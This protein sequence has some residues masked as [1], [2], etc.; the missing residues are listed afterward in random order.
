M[1]KLNGKSNQFRA[2]ETDSK[3][4]RFV[5]NPGRGWGFLILYIV[6][7]CLPLPMYIGARVVLH[8]PPS[9]L[10][11]EKVETISWGS[12][13]LGKMIF[14]MPIVF[15]PLFIS[16]LHHLMPAGSKCWAWIDNRTKRHITTAT[17]LYIIASTQLTDFFV[18]PYRRLYEIHNFSIQ[19]GRLV[20]DP[21]SLIVGLCFLAVS[22]KLYI[23]KK[24]AQKTNE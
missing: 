14:M 5:R 16:A 21:T 19:P 8:A 17:I 11:P 7:V 6:F 10:P 15:L 20:V 13:L 24:V 3:A 9:D 4:P 18:E 12:V 23:G 2:A 22:I 1:E